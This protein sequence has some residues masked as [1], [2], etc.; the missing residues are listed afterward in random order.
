MVR[1]PQYLE[2]NK[3]RAYSN[4]YL[5]PMAVSSADGCRNDRFEPFGG[6][7][8]LS[9]ETQEPDENQRALD[10]KPSAVGFLRELLLGN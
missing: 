2:V 8:L 7:A 1:L 6:C 10:E 5:P 9:Y 3:S 4:Q